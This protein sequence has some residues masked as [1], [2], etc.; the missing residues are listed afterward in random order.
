MSFTGIVHDAKVETKAV[1]NSS[2]AFNVDFSSP[3][4]NHLVVS[5]VVKTAVPAGPEALASS[6]LLLNWLM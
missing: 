3:S 5:L 2:P 1:Y 4:L 6:I